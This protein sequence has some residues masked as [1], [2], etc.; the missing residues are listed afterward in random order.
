MDNEER[1]LFA[2]NSQ[3]YLI[4]LVYEYPFDIKQKSGKVKIESNGLVSN[5]MWYF[6]RNDVYKRNEWS[7]YT[8]WPYENKIPNNLQELKDTNDENI[9]YPYLEII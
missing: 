3:E 5:W 9:F 8:N 2:N 7:N 6:Q 4:K 1:T